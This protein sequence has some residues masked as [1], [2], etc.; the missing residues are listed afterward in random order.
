MKFRKKPVIIDAEQ[1][2][3]KGKWI[4]QNPFQVVKTLKAY[5]NTIK[6]YESPLPVSD[7]VYGVET[8][9]GWHIVTNKDWIIKGVKGEFYPIKPDIFEMTYERANSLDQ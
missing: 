4:I 1:F 2:L 5:T 3:Q 9:E 8:L 6:G 7:K